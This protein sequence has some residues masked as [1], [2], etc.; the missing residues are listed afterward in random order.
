M[1]LILG[2]VSAN[3][4]QLTSKEWSSVV[5]H[6]QKVIGTYLHLPFHVTL[7]DRD[8]GEC[9]KL[10]ARLVNRLANSFPELNHW[11]CGSFEMSNVSFISLH[12]IALLCGN[13][14]LLSAVET[15]I[16]SESAYLRTNTEDGREQT[17]ELITANKASYLY[18]WRD[19]PMSSQSGP[20][21]LVHFPLQQTSKKYCRKES[22]SS[23]I[24]YTLPDSLKLLLR[25]LFLVHTQILI[26]L[27]FD[28]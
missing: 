12:S 18:R 5:Q 27:V 21:L 6:F 17:V 15:V 11:G 22:N 13:N 19:N 9:S 2:D 25:W 1:L 3:G 7:G 10:K 26:V 4:F 28:L 8:I 23:T 16:E 20:V 24:W 14:E